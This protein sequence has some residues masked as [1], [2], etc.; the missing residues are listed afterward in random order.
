M[1]RFGKGHSA[2]GGL[3]F[4]LRAD[5]GAAACLRGGAKEALQRDSRRS[6]IGNAAGLNRIPLRG[7]EWFA[8][9]VGLAV[10][11]LYIRRIGLIL[12]VL[13]PA[14]K[15]DLRGACKRPGKS[16]YLQLRSRQQ[17]NLDWTQP[18][19]SAASASR[20]SHKMGELRHFAAL[21]STH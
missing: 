14:S 20:R 17:R 21:I 7:Q 15:G 12:R 6:E 1:A 8:P 3:A 4:R 5:A 13:E 11:V 2:E 19:G 18:G 9:A 10:R 16:E